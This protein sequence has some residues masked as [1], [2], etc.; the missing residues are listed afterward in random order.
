[1]PAVKHGGLS[2][3]ARRVRYRNR[4]ARLH[5]KQL[6]D[7]YLK[8]RSATPHNAQYIPIR[9]RRE[10]LPSIVTPG[11]TARPN[12]D[13]QLTLPLEGRDRAD[14][15]RR[16]AEKKRAAVTSKTE[17]GPDK[18][19]RFP[20]RETSAAPLFK[21]PEEFRDRRGFTWRGFLVGCA[22]GG[23][24]AAFVLLILQT[25]TG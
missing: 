24:A 20:H 25:V 3:K 14:G 2:G 5:A 8:P 11:Q 13:T 12:R 15:P 19:I 6:I 10:F 7:D 9:G 23:A 4:A 17:T 21:R 1:M 18:V 22:M 16:A